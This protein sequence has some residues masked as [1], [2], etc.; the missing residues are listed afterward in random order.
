MDEHAQNASNGQAP[1]EPNVSASDPNKQ[2]KSAKEYAETFG[3]AVDVAEKVLRFAPLPVGV[4]RVAT[5]AMPAVK[6]VAQIAPT[7]APVIEP[8]ARKA[9]EHAKVVAPHVA[10]AAKTGAK[11]VASGA[12]TGAKALAAGTQA[13]AKAAAS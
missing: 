10:R 13:G 4:K 6:K 11:N 8:Y 3:K 7:V 12:Q 9:A 1:E 2:S 5:S